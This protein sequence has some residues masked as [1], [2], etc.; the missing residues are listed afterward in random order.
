M[1]SATNTAVLDAA[2]N[3]DYAAEIMALPQETADEAVKHSRFHRLT[4]HEFTWNL[5]FDNPW[6]QFSLANRP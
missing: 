3:R 1:P 4:F 6:G 2:L 5:A